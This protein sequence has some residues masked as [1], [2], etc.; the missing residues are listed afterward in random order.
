MA[1]RIYRSQREKIIAGVCGGIAE[2]F[3]TDPLWIRL[4][5][6]LLLFMNGIGILLYIVAWILMPKNPNQRQT[7]KTKAELAAQ[8][9]V[10]KAQKRNTNAFLGTILIIIGVAFLLNSFFNWFKLVLIFPIALIVIG[11]YLW[12]RTK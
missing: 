6:V 12:T 7:S 11:M 3:D 9:L 1:T 8:K 10:S 5:A 4:I 2:H